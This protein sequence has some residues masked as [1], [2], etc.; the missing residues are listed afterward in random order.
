MANIPEDL[1]YSK[2]HEWVRVEGG[3]GTIGITDHAQ[4]SLGDVV[5]V[6]LPKVGEKFGAH[7]AFGSVESVKAVS[8]LFSPVGGEVTEVNETLNDTPETVN[9]DPYGGAWMIKV[10]IN[11][12]GEVD[13]LMNA[14]EYEDYVKAE[15][16]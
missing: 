4:H 3:V 1:H 2:D 7:E 15:A 12:R 13:K 14:A 11:D 10:R 9:A 6:E 16:E 8:E 5:Y